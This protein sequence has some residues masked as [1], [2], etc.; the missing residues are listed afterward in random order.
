MGMKKLDDMVINLKDIYDCVIYPNYELSLI[1]NLDLGD[2]QKQKVLGK[3]ICDEKVILIDKSIAPETHDPRFIFTFGH[4]IGHGLLHNQKQ[5]FFRCTNDSIC[6]EADLYEKQ[7]NEFAENLIMPHNLV[8]YRYQQYYDTNKPFRYIGA[9]T[10]Y[11][12]HK[13]CQINSLLHLCKEIAKPLTPYFS[14][15][16]KES[17]GYSLIKLNLIQNETK[18]TINNFKEYTQTTNLLGSVLNNVLKI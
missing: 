14:H 12:N 11:L 9:T 3:T 6:N 4:E 15:I 2:H 18:E 13:R 8:K 10:Y 16:S 7:A 17:L 5:P 1:T